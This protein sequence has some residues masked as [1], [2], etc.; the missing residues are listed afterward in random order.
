MAWGPWAAAV[1][2]VTA[3]L[4]FHQLALR[5]S[6]YLRLHLR[7][8]VGALAAGALVRLPASLLE[9]GLQ[10]WAGI[11][12]MRGSGGQIPLLLHE[13]L[14]AAPLGQA[15]CVATVV[16]LWRLRRIRMRAGLPR[17][18]D[19]LEAVSFAT[20]AALGYAIV[21]VLEFWLGAASRGLDVVRGGLAVLCFVLLAAL[22]GFELGRHSHR[23]L[24]SRQFS[25]AWLLSALFTGICDRMIFR[26]GAGSLLAVV[27]LVLAM[28]FVAWVGWRSTTPEERL[29]VAGRASILTSAPAPSLGAIKEAFR[30]HD[31]PITIR[32]IALGA[33]VTTGLIATAVAAAVLLG[34]RLGLDFSAVDRAEA[35]AEAMGPTALLG[36]CVLLAFPAAGYL[37]ARASSARSVLEPALASV[38][39]I[40]LVLVFMG[41][42]APTSIVFVIAFAPIAFALTCAGAWLGSGG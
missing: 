32:W 9:R 34:H 31:Q 5:R 6:S 7:Y 35:G 39:A 27:P 41:M 13:F 21:K 42:M 10:R 19:T 29:S 15:L 3:A 26:G 20:S 33:F 12:S 38:L 30:R 4:G 22:W 40:V 23:G 17:D 2:L 36:A 1:V 11:D 8:W 37:L 24:S 28:L 14:V 16:A 25:V 18:L